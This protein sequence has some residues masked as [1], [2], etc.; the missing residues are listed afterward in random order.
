MIGINGNEGN[1][2]IHSYRGN[3]GNSYMGIEANHYSQLSNGAT[4]HSE[5]PG[6]QLS[7]SAGAVV[8][9]WHGLL[10]PIGWMK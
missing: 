8:S 5:W 1:D 2:N 10:Q 7:S 6:D 9:K 3:D 4:A